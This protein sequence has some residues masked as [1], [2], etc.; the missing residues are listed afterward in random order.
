MR[1]L[2]F[3]AGLFFFSLASFAQG[4]YAGTH[5]KWI[6]REVVNQKEALFFKGY[7]YVGYSLLQSDEEIEYALLIYRK[8]F[9]HILLL[10]SQI[11]DTLSYTIQ[12]VIEIKA[13][14]IKDNI[15]QGTC[16]WN[17][18]INAKVIVLEKNRNNK[19]VNT[20]AWYTDT[21]KLR[22]TAIPVKG[23]SCIAE[24]AD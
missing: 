16:N 19:P 9:T 3:V 12:D 24:G 23:I 15:Q 7:T 13:V 4:V 1:K 18:E 22:F 2:Y 8:G 5:K 14:S 6:K 20:K 21:D 17:G 11:K 10:T